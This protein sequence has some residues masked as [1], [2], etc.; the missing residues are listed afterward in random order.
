MFWLIV[1]E[2]LNRYLSQSQMKKFAIILLLLPSMAQAYCFKEAGERYGIEPSL[3]IAIAK[4]ESSM[5]PKAKSPVGA[6]GL[7]QIYKSWF[8]TLHKR[9]GI[10]E[11]QLWQ[12]CTNVMVGAWI[13]ANEFQQRGRNWNAIGAYNA[14]CTK[15]KGVECLRARQ[16]YANSVWRNLQLVKL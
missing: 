12:P 1:S 2:I 13:L 16:K 5:N 10:T 3:L 14:A 8:P 9:F 6:I 7:M 4:T 11:Q 15:L